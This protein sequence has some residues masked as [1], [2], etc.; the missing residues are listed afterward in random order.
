[1]ETYQ[2]YAGRIRNGQPVI[3]GNAV[4]PENASIFV[5]VLCTT[6]PAKPPNDNHND[7]VGR[8]QAHLDAIEKFF[9]AMAEIDDEPLDEEF[10]AILAKRMNITRE[11]D[12]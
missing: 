11:L 12:L 10:D 1:M 9:K 6:T 8:R 2:T 7:L 4:L 3:S 5:T